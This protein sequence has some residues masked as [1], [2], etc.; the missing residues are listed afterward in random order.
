M[1]T[2]V[3]FGHSKMTYQNRSLE[4]WKLI[5]KDLNLEI[6]AEKQKRVLLIFRQ[7]TFVLKTSNE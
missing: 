3:N 2:L 7:A 4:E 1:D 5:F 6:I